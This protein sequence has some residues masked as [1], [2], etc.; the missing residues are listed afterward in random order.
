MN[1]QSNNH[2]PI[3]DE[4]FEAILSL[5]DLDECYDFFGDLFTMQELTTFAQRLQVAKLLYEEHTYEMVRKQF[6]VSNATITRVST[7]LHYGKGGYRKV[8]ETMYQKKPTSE[9]S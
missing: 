8:L 3:L 2:S 9:D 5:K 4:L 1:R 6:P 7:A